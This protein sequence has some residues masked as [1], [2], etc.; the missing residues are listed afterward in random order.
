MGDTN[1]VK[2]KRHTQTRRL[3]TR[4]GTRSQNATVSTEPVSETTTKNPS[5]VLPDELIGEILVRVPV[6]SLI[7]FKCVCKSWKTLISDPQFAKRHHLN[8]NS[9]PQLFCPLFGEG[10]LDIVSYNVESLLENNSTNSNPITPY[11]TFATNHNYV[12]VGLC[13]GLFCLIDIEESY[14]ILWNPLLNLKSKKSP[15]MVSLYGDDDSVSYHGFGYDHVNDK[16]K[17]LVNVCNFNKYGESV[18]RIYT[19]GENSWKTIENIPGDPDEI[20]F[21]TSTGRLVSGNLNWVINKDINSNEEVIITFDIMNET[22]GEMLLPPHDGEKMS[23]VML[24][25]LS[26]CLSLCFES[27]Q[28]KW[29]VWM[30]KEYGVGESWTKLMTISN[31]FF[32]IEPRMVEAE[33][34]DEPVMI[35]NQNVTMRP[36][37][38]NSLFISEN[39]TILVN[40]MRSKIVLYNSCHGRSHYPIISSFININELE[41]YHESLVLPE[42]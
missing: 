14:V 37:Y 42:W 27:N 26:D 7:Q 31:V 41:F 28:S 9:Y 34:S 30:M 22:Y 12:I 32:T 1:N 11:N 35:P 18:T 33:S 40:T 38:V 6:R 24:D 23:N 17:V 19:S 5:P 10:D 25:V 29:V 15:T 20:H 13:K 4:Y 3:R 2:T 39:G 21:D 16:Y 8:S 36:S